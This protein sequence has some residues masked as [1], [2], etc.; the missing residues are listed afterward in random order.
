[1]KK[2]V[3]LLIT[4]LSWH[5][6]AI[7][8]NDVP[9]QVEA[10][11]QA[12]QTFLHRHFAHE[13]VALA[14]CDDGWFNKK[15]EVILTSGIKIEFNSKGRWEEVKCKYSQVPTP[16]L[17]PAIRTYLSKTYPSAKVI[18]IEHKHSEWE[19][20]LSTGEEIT[21]NEKFQVTEID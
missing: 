7:A 16:I 6:S 12:A 18:E 14:K 2:I 8:D 3:V 5:A 20:K 17:P 4:L 11:P 9:I 19:V 1:M 21:F 15:Y 13:K 10:L